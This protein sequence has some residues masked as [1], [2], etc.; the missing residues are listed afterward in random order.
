MNCAERAFSMASCA[1]AVAFTA[2]AE[3]DSALACAS[4]M[5]FHEMTTFHCG[6]GGI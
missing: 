2:S 6:G 3:C 4:S 1:T 5:V